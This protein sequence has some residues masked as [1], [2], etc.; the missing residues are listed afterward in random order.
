MKPN[1]DVETAEIAILL[2]WWHSPEDEENFFR[3]LYSIEGYESCYGS[4]LTLYVTFRIAKIDRDAARELLAIFRR[5][6]LPGMS[7]LA[8]IKRSPVG[9]WFASRKRDWHEEVFEAPAP[10]GEQQETPSALS[11]GR[12]GQ[13][14]NVYPKRK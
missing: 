7:Q 1:K 2:G 10:A 11:I 3:W 4:D 8:F 9:R 13:H 14:R 12:E 6:E 5:Y